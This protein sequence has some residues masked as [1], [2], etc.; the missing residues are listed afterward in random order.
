MKREV[1]LPNIIFYQTLSIYVQQI[2]TRFTFV[3]VITVLVLAA[4]ALRWYAK[5]TGEATSEDSEEWNQKLTEDQ[6]GNLG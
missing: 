6:N 2:T 1:K 5:L 4:G 3:S